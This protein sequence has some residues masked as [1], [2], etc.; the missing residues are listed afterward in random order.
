MKKDFILEVGSN[1]GTDT[2]SLAF[3]NPD[4]QIVGFEPTPELLVNYLYKL[5]YEVKNIKIFPFAIDEEEAIKTFN[6][7]G[8]NDWGCS[9]LHKFTDD[10]QNVWQNRPDFKFTHSIDVLCLRGDTICKMLDIESIK[11]LWIDT[12]GN[13]FR[14]LKS[15]GQYLD[16]VQKGKCEAAYNVDLYKDVDNNY[17]NIQQFLESK[18]FKTRIQPDVVN[19]ECDVHFWRE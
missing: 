11:Y 10:I 8:Q 7:A 15:F 17:L 18:G 16:I 6:I 9:S 5:Q 4:C 1:R 19:K 3:N 14:T 13:D 12:Q 2:I